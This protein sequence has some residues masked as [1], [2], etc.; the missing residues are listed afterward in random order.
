MRDDL[1]HIAWWRFVD[2]KKALGVA[3]LPPRGIGVWTEL[4]EHASYIPAFGI[5]IFDFATDAIQATSNMFGTAICPICLKLETPCWRWRDAGHTGYI[6]PLPTEGIIAFPPLATIEEDVAARRQLTQAST[7]G[8]LVSNSADLR[9]ALQT[10]QRPIVQDR[11]STTPS[12]P[13]NRERRRQSA[14]ETSLESLPPVQQAPTP[15]GT[16]RCTHCGQVIPPG[17][18][19]AKDSKRTEDE[20]YAECQHDFDSQTK[21]CSKCK[22]KERDRGSRFSWLEVD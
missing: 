5:I 4:T 16:I 12:Q 17:F 20:I 22:L 2:L 3:V 15:M 13:N 8:Q 14:V 21:I 6:P 11:R 10:R 18:D 1:A 7:V 19:K 9:A